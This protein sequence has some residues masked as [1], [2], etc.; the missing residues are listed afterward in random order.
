MVVMENTPE[1]PKWFTIPEAAQYLE[2]G[3]QTLYRWM[4]EET[5]TY[6]KVGDSTRFLQEDLDAVVQVRWSKH[7]TERMRASCPAC[8][9]TQMTPGDLQS[10]GRLY[11]R[12]H[13]TKFWTLKDSNVDLEAR[14]CARCGYLATYADL[15][16]VNAL[17][18][19]PGENGWE[20][21]EA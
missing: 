18:T 21:I 19:P 6:R 16:K 4:R 14:I 10:T 17:T 20:E 7:D 13:K 9:H 12:P 2:V 1:K 15:Q 3:E 11:F 5:I 8:H